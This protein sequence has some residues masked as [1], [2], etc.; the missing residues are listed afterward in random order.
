MIV[1]G[2][3]VVE[4]Y[5]A[6]HASHKGIRAARAQFDTWL[7][8]AR[9]AEWRSPEGVKR[10]HPASILK[11]GQR[12]SRFLRQAAKVDSAMKRIIHHED[13]ETVFG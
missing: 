10:S 1:A 11:G 3:D 5:F 6:D 9:R 2:T 7:S 4:R 13:A 8:I 12:W